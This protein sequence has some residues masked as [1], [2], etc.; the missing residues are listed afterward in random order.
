MTLLPLKHLLVRLLACLLLTGVFLPAAEE[1]AVLT[2]VFAK[3]EKGYKRKKTPEGG[4]Q[5][6]YY[7]MSNGGPAEGTIKDNAQDKIQFASLARVLAEHLARQGY[8]PATDPKKVDLLIV[9][10]WGRTTPL[11]DGAYRSGTDNVLAAMNAL[12]SL[13][14]ATPPPIVTVTDA[15]SAPAAEVNITGSVEDIQRQ[16]AA[17]RL[18]GALMT[19]AMFNRSRDQANNK[20]ATVLGYSQ[21]L[22]KSDGIQR[23]AG[24]G[25]K[26]EELLADI[27]EPRYYVILKAFDFKKTV[28]EKKPKM[29]WVTRMSMRAPGNSFAKKA[30]A[31]VAYGAS[32]FGQNT[33]GLERKLSPGYRVNLEDVK[34][35]GVEE[36]TAP[37]AAS[38]G[39]TK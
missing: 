18:E 7:A 19:Q 28:H 12:T 17:S 23:M 37:A 1:D 34:F 39:E 5:R 6:E 25:A 24:G 8:F 13:G 31:M 35:L 15:A 36:K 14:P 27:E 22:S 9:V 30:A 21:D 33:D 10:N 3:T 4:W 16:A 38:A 2:S 20:N 32:R 29:Q 26:Y 11:N